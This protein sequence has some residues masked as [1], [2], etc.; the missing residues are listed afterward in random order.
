MG[1][2]RTGPPGPVLQRRPRSLLSLGLPLKDG[3]LAVPVWGHLF[4]HSG[5][6]FL[7]AVLVLALLGIKNVGE[8]Q[9]GQN[10]PNDTTGLVSRSHGET[11][12]ALVTGSPKLSRYLWGNHYV[13][14]W[15]AWST[16]S[17]GGGQEADLG[18]CS[19][20]SEIPVW[21]RALLLTRH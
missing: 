11:P 13:S 15:A 5:W 6:T 10:S 1:M 4:F 21:P 18:G 9:H 16:G 12:G 7:P 3:G 19:P 8:I 14:S 2:V 17:E 20:R